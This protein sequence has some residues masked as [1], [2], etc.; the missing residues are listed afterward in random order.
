MAVGN[1]GVGAESLQAEVDGLKREKEFLEN[2]LKYAKTLAAS[3]LQ[4]KSGPSNVT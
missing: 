4:R 1:N 3:Y 2:D